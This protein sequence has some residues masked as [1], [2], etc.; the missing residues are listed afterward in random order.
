MESK[1]THEFHGYQTARQVVITPELP[2]SCCLGI[3]GL[4]GSRSCLVSI[5]RTTIA[6]FLSVLK[7]LHTVPSMHRKQMWTTGIS[8]LYRSAVYVPLQKSLQNSFDVTVCVTVPEEAHNTHRTRKLSVIF[9]HKWRLMVM[10]ANA[11]GISCHPNRTLKANLIKINFVSSKFKVFKKNYFDYLST[12]TFSVWSW[13]CVTTEIMLPLEGIHFE[14][15][16]CF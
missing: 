15:M 14:I 16:E 6:N 11:Q 7:L 13:S 3:R 2:W 10:T 5:L 9:L 8:D 1:F 4:N 12:N